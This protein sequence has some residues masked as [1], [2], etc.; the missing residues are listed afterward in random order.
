[1]AAP[2]GQEDSMH[3]TAIRR[4]ALVPLTFVLTTTS[5]PTAGLALARDL[6]ALADHRPAAAAEIAAEGD[7]DPRR[8]LRL[9]V[10]LAPRNR[11]TL[12]RLL[13]A[14]HDPAS[15]H[16]HRWLSSA[17]YERRFGPTQQDVDAVTQWLATQ[18]FTVTYAN[19]SEGR[20]A[21]EGSAGTAARAFQVRIAGSRDGQYYGN[22]SDPV[23]PAA[24][25]AKVAYVD[26]LHNLGASH[27]N[28]RIPEPYNNQL[29]E[30]HFGPPDVW[31]YHNARPLLDMGMNGTGQCIAALSGSEVDQE[32]LDL[33]TG[34]FGLPPFVRG[35]NFNAVYPDGD[36]GIQPPVNGAA[37]AYGEALLDIQWAHGLAPG[38]EIVLYAGNYPTLGTQ[39]LVNTLI[40]A[41]TD[42][43]CPV[44]TISWA[45]CG[46][47]KSFFKMLDNSYKRGAA[48]GQTIFVAT[49]D[50]GVAGPTNGKKGGGCQIPSKP[51]I[52]ENAGSPN[53]TAVGATM[54]R[55]AQYDVDGYNTGVGVPA[56]E[57]WYFNIQNLIQSATT[58]GV[59]KVFKRPKWQ[60][61]IKSVKFKK[62]AVPD[63]CLGGGVPAFPGYWECLDFGLYGTGVPEGATCTTGGGTSVAAPQWAAVAAII[64][65]KIGRIGNINPKLYAMAKA[66]LADLSAVGIRDVTVGHNGYAPLTGY[67]AVAGF[68]LA[69]GWGSV[70]ITAFVNAFVAAP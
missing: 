66:N 26:G 70:D 17:E 50:V 35:G 63:I 23:L 11:A 36:P 5:L 51:N 6:V 9:Q 27:M 65:Q 58:G 20:I 54:I 69:S 39:G 60:K 55:G 43:R 49:G 13:E 14:Q 56:E 34:F 16:Y 62:R 33:F 3:S 44:I 59:S 25:A 46:M 19:A 8:P 21:F 2:G 24:L 41:T 28:T 40:A 61:G 4:A 10:Y 15:P 48:Q 38:A 29:D 37:E 32:S 30:Q 1:M 52:E 18:G 45:Q 64:V 68:D 7:A 12:D 67:D 47:P 42:N 53:V 57:V 22:V 31:T